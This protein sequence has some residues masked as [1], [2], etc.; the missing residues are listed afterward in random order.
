MTLLQAL[1]IRRLTRA[2]LPHCL[3]L[4]T[5]RGWT[6][7]E[8]TWRLLLTAGTGYGVED[9]QGRGLVGCCV[10]TRYARAS[11]GRQPAEPEL[12]GVGALLVATRYQ[13]R[14]LGRRLMRHALEEAAGATVFLHATAG[15]R[16]LHEQLGFKASS[17]LATRTGR[18]RA[19]P[20]AT[21]STRSAT[22]ADLPAMLHLDAEVFGADRTHLLIRLPAFAEQV[23]VAERNGRLS[24]FAATWRDGHHT[25][26]GPVVA[27]DAATARGL[28]A[29]LAA[30][31]EG[32]IRLD[33]DIRHRQLNVWLDAHGLRPT[34]VNSVMVHGSPDL[35]GDHRRRFAPFSV[36]LG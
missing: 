33:T 15:S 20:G 36:A 29:D 12:A 16:S 4:C 14:G 3:D 13:G 23:R 27:E 18:L 22:A 19:D 6:R 21:G 28:V 17:L 8:R 35:P 26:V 10:L 9:P 5:D 11:Y 7:E 30:R 1:P 25:V 24:G 32:E 34:T 31:T 2:D